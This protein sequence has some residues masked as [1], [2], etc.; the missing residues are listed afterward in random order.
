MEINEKYVYRWRALELLPGLTI[1]SFR[2]EKRTSE[3]DC[4]TVE[5][6]RNPFRF[7]LRK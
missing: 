4:S 1:L 2:R 3:S 7:R 5:I 6:V